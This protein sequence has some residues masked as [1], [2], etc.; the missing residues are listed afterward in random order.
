MSEVVS[1]SRNGLKKTITTKIDGE[2]YE[3]RR[4]GAG[5][6]LDISQKAKKLIE[7]SK[8]YINQKS[9]LLVDDGDSE[10]ILNKANKA[11]EEIAKAQA[12]LESVYVGLFKPLSDNADPAALVRDVGIDNIPQLIDM[13]FGAKNEE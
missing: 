5:D 1:I 3:V 6:Q 11:L 4:I 2:V 8:K 12:E 9:K 13:A 7:I 10:E